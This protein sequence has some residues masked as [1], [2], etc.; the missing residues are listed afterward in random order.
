MKIIFAGTPDFSVGCLQALI[1]AGHDVVAVYCQP[2]RP[3]GRGRK[4]QTGPVK[5]CALDN[6]I[7]VLQPLSLKGEAEQSE[8]A[9]LDADLMV[10]VAYGLILPQA[11]L[12]TPRYGCINVHA[13][14]L[15]RWR[16]AAP[17]QR[18]IEA[19]D[20]ETGVTIMQM[21]AGL[22]TGDML[23]KVTLAI[24]TDM[25]GGEL[26]DALAE[27]GAEALIETVS[28][29]PEGL[30]PEAQD[31]SQANYAHKLDKQDAKIDWQQSAENIAAKVRAFNPWPVCWTSHEEQRQRIWAAVAEQGSAKP[32]HIVSADKTG[33]VIGTGNGLLRIKKLQAPGNKPLATQDFANGH[34]LNA[35]L[36]SDFS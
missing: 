4:L 1:D 25:T 23:R 26:H 33:I 5:Q 29:I 19:G 12:D 18:C 32:G 13:S 6:N 34:D 7:P 11:V 9:A 22:D 24:G 21:D 30:Q 14:L 3:A 2:D 17:I 16:G 27:I 10:V 20:T 8:L 28:A 36:G 35:W 31:D 15:P